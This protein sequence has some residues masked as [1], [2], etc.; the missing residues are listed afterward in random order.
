MLGW[1]ISVFRQEGGG[2]SPATFESPEGT[3]IAAWQTGWRGLEWLDDLVKEGKALD[4]GGTGYPCRYTA[5]AQVLLPR[6]IDQPPGARANW[7][8]D[9]GDVVNEKWEGTTAVNQA[10]AAL[11]RPDEWLLV[12]AW[13]ES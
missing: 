9:A 11:C 2:A 4:L 5:T 7:V 13:D 3:R 6:V 8:A 10:V 12:V 1:N